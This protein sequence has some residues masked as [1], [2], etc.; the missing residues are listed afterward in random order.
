MNTFVTTFA[1]NKQSHAQTPLNTSFIK[2]GQG[3]KRSL[4]C[5]PAPPTETL[6]Y[7]TYVLKT[8]HSVNIPPLFI[9]PCYSMCWAAQ[10]A[11]CFQQTPYHWAISSSNITSPGKHCAAQD[12][13]VRKPSPPASLFDLH[14]VFCGASL[15]TI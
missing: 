6:F 13:L 8:C 15:H 2:G 5:D 14:H 10:N 7:P 9:P 1:Q 12:E 11:H 3:K 4:F